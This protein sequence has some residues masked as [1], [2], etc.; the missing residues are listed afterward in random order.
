[1]TPTQ[2]S[3]AVESFE[4]WLDRHR[5]STVAAVF[6][7]IMLRHEA[8]RAELARPKESC[9]HVFCYF[10]DQPKR[11]CVNCS[12]V[13]SSPLEVAPVGDL[14]AEKQQC[15]AW[16]AVVN[17]LKKINPR[18]LIGPGTG[19]EHAV[20]EI[21]RLASRV[22]VALPASQGPAIP[23]DVLK[24]AISFQKDGYRGP[25]AWARKVFDWVV[26]QGATPAP[27]Q[28]DAKDAERYQFIRRGEASPGSPFIARSYPGGIS[29][30][31]DEVADRFIDEAILASKATA[32][33]EGK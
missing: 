29:Q 1:M 30:W 5:D 11:R 8:L 21:E 33:G 32:A 13:E 31:T 12:A 16:F 20:R 28:G 3:Q 19:E 23:A 22:P 2:P 9:Q 24:A 7:E 27:K 15:H 25:L 26:E 10:G 14:S 4:E 6:H 18:F 17:V